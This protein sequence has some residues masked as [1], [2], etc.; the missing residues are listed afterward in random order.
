MSLVTFGFDCNCAS[1]LKNNYLILGIFKCNGIPVKMHFKNQTFVNSKGFKNI[2]KIHFQ[3]D[4]SQGNQI[5]G[6]TREC[7]SENLCPVMPVGRAG[8]VSAPDLSVKAM[9]I[10]KALLSILFKWHT[11]AETKLGSTNTL[12]YQPS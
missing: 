1:G 4:L 12:V 10:S 8:E 11:Q 5:Q 6:V 7:L 2:S 9:K 3:S